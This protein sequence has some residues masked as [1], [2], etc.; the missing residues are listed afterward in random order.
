MAFFFSL[1]KPEKQRQQTGREISKA[2]THRTGNAKDRECPNA[3]RV[4]GPRCSEA[5]AAL[6]LASTRYSRS[7]TLKTPLLMFVQIALLSLGTLR[8]P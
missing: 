8:I 1:C 3:I 2:D 6:S 5:A 7:Y 4:P